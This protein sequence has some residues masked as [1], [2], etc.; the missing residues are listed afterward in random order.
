MVDAGKELKVQIISPEYKLLDAKK[1]EQL[2]Q[3]GFKVLPWTVN[4]I[5]DI[6]HM[7]DMHVDGIITSYPKRAMDYIQSIK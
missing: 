3:N 2:H 7:L 1:V 6:Q 4:R 5:T